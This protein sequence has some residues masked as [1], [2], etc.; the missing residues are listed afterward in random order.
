MQ[1][2]AQTVTAPEGALEDGPLEMEDLALDPLRRE[3]RKLTIGKVLWPAAGLIFLVGMWQA[4]VTVFHVKPYLV[5]SPYTV[6]QELIDNRSLFLSNL[7]PTALESLL[8]FA[9]GNI[10]GIL[11]ALSFVF[12]KILRQAFYPAATILWTVP[13]VAIAPLLI[14]YLGFGYSPKI[15]VAALITFFPTLVNMVAGFQ[16]ADPQLMELMRVL[17][18]RRRDIFLKLQL[19][20]SVPYLFAALKIAAPGAVIGA[21]VAEWIGSTQGIGFLIVNATHNFQAPQLYGAMT[22]ASAF[23]LALLGLVVLTQRIMHRWDRAK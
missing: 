23:A 5:S 1:A 22:V 4:Y 2:R 18:A 12:S 21:I 11:I 19:P 3:R 13:I 20:S 17:S 14:L 16:S 9:V 7:Y 15:A 8:G 6:A 10:A